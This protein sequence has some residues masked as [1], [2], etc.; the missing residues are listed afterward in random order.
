MTRTPT[1]HAKLTSK[2]SLDAMAEH[3]RAAETIERGY[4]DGR[5]DS[6]PC[7]LPPP[8]IRD[9]VLCDRWTEGYRK[10]WAERK[11]TT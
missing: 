9:P 7:E 10:A 5:A 1:H 6:Q 4:R 11:A 2:N 3:Y 8:D